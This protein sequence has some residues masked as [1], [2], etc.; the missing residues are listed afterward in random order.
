MSILDQAY[1]AGAEAAFEKMAAPSRNMDVATRVGTGLL[2]AGLGSGAGMLGANM[3]E[4]EDP[5]LAGA[6]MGGSTALGAGLGAYAPN[7]TAGVAGDLGGGVLGTVGGEAL[8]D[9]LAERFGWDE[10]KSQDIAGRIGRIGG[11]I[12]G[13]QLGYRGMKALRGDK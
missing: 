3:G 9:F 5:R 7:A 13:S 2:G 12:G 10:H 11:L 6:I 1:R 4:V 8:G